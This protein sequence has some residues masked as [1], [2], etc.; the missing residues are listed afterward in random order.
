[1]KKS[2]IIL[3]LMKQEKNKFYLYLFNL[4]LTFAKV[5]SDVVNTKVTEYCKHCG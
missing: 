5:R 1:M 3:L 4:H 2:Y